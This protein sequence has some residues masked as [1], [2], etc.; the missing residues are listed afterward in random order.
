MNILGCLTQLSKGELWPT[1]LPL[2]VQYLPRNVPS[3]DRYCQLFPGGVSLFVWNGAAVCGCTCGYLREKDTEED[4][5]IFNQASQLRT[6]SYL[7]WRST[8]DKPGRRWANCAPP[9][10]PL[11]L[12]CSLDSNQ[13]LQWRPLH[14]DAAAPLGSIAYIIINTLCWQ[15]QT[16]SLDSKAR[17]TLSLVSARNHGSFPF[18]ECWQTSQN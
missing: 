18:P 14:W 4:Q 6:N 17:R 3:F 8:P 12:R 7:Q 13:G 16:P 2:L 10:T 15:H 9:V 5:F 1:V 11:A